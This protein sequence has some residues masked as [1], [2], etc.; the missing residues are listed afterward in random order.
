[1]D[2]AQ[3]LVTTIA[4]DDSAEAG[5]DTDRQMAITATLHL[6]LADGSRI[7]LLDDRGWCSAGPTGIWSHETVETMA[8]TARTVV[9]PDEP[10]EGRTHEDEAAMHWAAVAGTAQQLGVALT[11]T[12]IAQL[13]HDVE[14]STGIQERLAR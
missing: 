13:P 7:V 11:A 4:I 1:M 12:E 10:P 8:E 14:A 2:A 6:E 9:G 5:Q 3:R